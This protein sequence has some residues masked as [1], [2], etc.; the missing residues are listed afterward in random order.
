M[1]RL[2]SHSFENVAQDR[3]IL[4]WLWRGRE[5]RKFNG[6]CG[7]EQEVKEV[8]V[9]GVKRVRH[10]L[11]DYKGGRHHPLVWLGW[12]LCIVGENI[13]PRIRSAATVDNNLKR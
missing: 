6:W 12:L 9:V 2:G 4:S 5:F 1:A 10:C 11:R 8:L 7:E 3:R 13:I